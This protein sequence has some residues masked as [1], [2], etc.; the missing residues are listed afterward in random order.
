M[1]RAMMVGF[2][3]AVSIGPVAAREPIRAVPKDSPG[4]WFHD[5]D[6]PI[7]ERAKGVSGT[8]SFKLLI[9][10]DGRVKDCNVESSSGSPVLDE[11]ACTLLKERASFFPAKDRRGKPVNGTYN[12]RIS[13]RLP[14]HSAISMPPPQTLTVT[15]DISKD[16]VVEKCSFEKSGDFTLPV[17][18]CLR[19][20]VGSKG[21]PYAGKNGLPFPIRFVNRMTTTVEAR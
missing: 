11:T 21:P 8:T 13:W 15:V 4:N 16:D 5:K 6:Y 18:P 1:K 17:D 10:D 12:G 7:S 19:F 14:I 3:L 20:P 2:L 9:G